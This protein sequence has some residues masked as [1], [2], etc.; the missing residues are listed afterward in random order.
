[1]ITNAAVGISKVRAL[2]YVNA[3]IPDEGQSVLDLV[4]ARPGSHLGG[5]PSTVFDFVPYPGAPAGDADVYVKRSVY[6]DVF[7]A[8]LSPA[9]INVLAATQRPITF[10]ALGEKSGPVAWDTIPS[11]A[12]VGTVDHAVPPAEQLAMARHAK[13]KITRIK[14]PHLSMLVRPQQV[15]KVI[16][17]AARAVG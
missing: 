9:A 6:R 11:W 16:D 7:A 14:A 4:M 1:V 10:S 13:A 17:R 8:H 3:F 12:V 5:D 2:V 15:T